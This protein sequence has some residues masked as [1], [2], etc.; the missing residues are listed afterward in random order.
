MYT[1]YG[2]RYYPVVGKKGWH[3][4]PILWDNRDKAVEEAWAQVGGGHWTT[5]HVFAVEIDPVGK[6]VA[7]M[8][9]TDDK[10]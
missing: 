10:P 7:S 4:Y 6:T 1:F 2:I 8:G 5:A 9:H 3:V